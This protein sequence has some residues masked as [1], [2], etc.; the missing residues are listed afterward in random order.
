MLSTLAKVASLSVGPF[1]STPPPSPPRGR[2]ASRA[3]IASRA[4]ASENDASASDAMKKKKT[5]DVVNPH[6]TIRC[7]NDQGREVEL[8]TTET[9]ASLTDALL[10]DVRSPP[11]IEERDMATP[12][13]LNVWW[14]KQ[15]GG[16]H[17]PE[18]LEG[19]PKDR[20]IVT[21]CG[22]GGRAGLA[23]KYLEEEMGFT[24]VYN[25]GVPER[26]RDAVAKKP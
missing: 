3:S 24:R 26:V 20:P 16:F 7:L 5:N 19:V 2:G 21:N 4:M 18:L 6:D 13:A 10:V 15:E 23:K 17:H 22:S 1:A 9:L 8:A 12:D 14:N 25:G 11:E